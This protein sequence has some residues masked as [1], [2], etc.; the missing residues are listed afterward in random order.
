MANQKIED[1]YTVKSD[2]INLF[3][4]KAPTIIPETDN[5]KVLN[6]AACI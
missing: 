5:G 6:R 1:W 4:K 2:S 3:P